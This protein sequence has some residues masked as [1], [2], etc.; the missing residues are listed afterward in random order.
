[1]P[2]DNLQAAE[3]H[4]RGQLSRTQKFRLDVLALEL[5]FKHNGQK[6]AFWLEEQM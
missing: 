4:F 5:V 6:C 3:F 1:M 2:L